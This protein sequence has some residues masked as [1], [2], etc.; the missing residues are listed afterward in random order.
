MRYAILSDIHANLEAFRAVLAMIGK[1][2]ADRVLCLGDIVGYG[3]DPNACVDLV[4]SEGI[5]SVMGNHDAAAC[6]I[7]EPDHFNLNARQALYWTR[8][9]LTP[10]NRGYLQELPRAMQIEELFFCHGTVNETNRYLLYDSDAQENFT[11]MEQLPGSPRLCFFGHTHIRVSYSIA[12]PVVGR[13]PADGMF[14]ADDKRYLVN[15]GSVGQP[16]DG[17]ARAAFLLY[18]AQ[19]HTIAFHRV[20]YDIASCQD[21]IIQAGLPARLAERLAMGR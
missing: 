5:V 16:R 12:G 8:G 3:A 6:G 14:L 11:L 9:R 2:G 18:D 4:R 20:E 7:E 19:E 15:P 17:D 10:E 13:E 1:L 21:K